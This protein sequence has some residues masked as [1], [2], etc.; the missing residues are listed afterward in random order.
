MTAIAFELFG[1]NEF[2]ARLPAA[3][4]ALASVLLCYGIGRELYSR[5][6]GWLAGVILAT[7]LE[8]AMMARAVQ[9]D[10][11]FAL[12]TTLALF[13]YILAMREQRPARRYWVLFY[14]AIGLA[15]LTKGPLGMVLVGIAVV[16]HLLVTGSARAWLR[17]M[18][19]AGI[20]VF[21]AVT[22]PWYVLI[23]LANPGY[24]DYFVIQ[25][26]VGNVLGEFGEYVARHPEPVYYY[27]PVFI[28]AMLP[29]SLT[30]PQ[31]VYSALRYREARLAHADILLVAFFAGSLLLMSAATSK[32]A[33][34][35]LPT[36]PVAAVLIGRY[37]DRL[38]D[39]SPRTISRGSC[40]ASAPCGSWPR[41][42][43]C[44]RSSAAAS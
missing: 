40:W 7:S 13:A 29:W 4:S 17:A 8:F 32:L 10:M 20:L 6:A 27:I 3:L 25:Q 15:V 2:A 39:A 23:E 37:W 14:L 16:T 9:Y 19:P 41:C 11:L 31:S 12:F 34:Y 33:T 42:L 36:L 21:S 35:I 38:F 1:R 28:G 43:R 24:I 30:L 5:R 22:V 26:H 18:N 44:R